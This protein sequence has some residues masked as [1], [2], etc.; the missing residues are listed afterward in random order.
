MKPRVDPSDPDEAFASIVARIGHLGLRRSRRV[1]LG[2]S[3]GAGT[4]AVLVL[5]FG[6]RWPWQAVVT[7]AVTFV[8]AL[9][10]GLAVMIGA[11]QRRWK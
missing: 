4:A 7:F 11:M 5:A 10:A 3:T 2:V 6:L 9:G 1:A 8:I